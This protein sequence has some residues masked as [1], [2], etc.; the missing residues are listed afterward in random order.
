M[1]DHDGWRIDP[2]DAA[3]S[4]TTLG[5]LLAIGSTL[6]G[7]AQRLAF[8]VAG[9]RFALSLACSRCGATHPAFQL[10]RSLRQAPRLC[11]S[12]HGE[13]QPTGF[14]LHDAVAMDGAPEAAMDA[15]LAQLGLR[16]GDVVSLTT[17]AADVHYEL[18]GGDQ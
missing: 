13:L 4:E 16:A 3:A 14:T 11:R 10:E 12:C 5:E 18:K 6:R 17:P 15:P 7:A 8:G 9:Q 1:P 2:I